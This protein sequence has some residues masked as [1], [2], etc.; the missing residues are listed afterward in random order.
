MDDE[1]NK[2]LKSYS[3]FTRGRL[4][5]AAGS[6]AGSGQGL[7]ASEQRLEARGW[8]LVR[9]RRAALPFPTSLQPPASLYLTGLMM[10]SHPDPAQ[11][12]QTGDAEAGRLR[13]RPSPK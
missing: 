6:T 1:S 9:E 7:E 12:T 13:S 8:R 3:R 11:F 2:G 5:N 4:S 10:F